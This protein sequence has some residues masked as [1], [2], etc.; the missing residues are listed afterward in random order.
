MPKEKDYFSAFV[1]VS[2]AIS[3]TLDLKEVLELI[4]QKAV[5]SLSLKAGIISLWN[6]KENRLELITHRNLS[7]EFLNKGPVLADKSMPEAITN[8]KPAIVP[9]IE[10]DSQLQ[11]P[12]ACRKEGI[13]AIL[14]VPIVFKDEVMGILRLYDSN[15]KEF[16]YREV[17]FMTA[18]AE[19]GGIAIE[20][21]RYM[22]K[23]EKSHKQEME[24]LWDWFNSMSGASMLDG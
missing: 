16:T 12:D 14:S 8:K 5:D 11:Y 17:E 9:N 10:D 24:E 3:S 22:Q 21:A 13:G 18:L 20:N 4:L 6:K 23:M 19:Q 2:K 15:P 1:S 7:E